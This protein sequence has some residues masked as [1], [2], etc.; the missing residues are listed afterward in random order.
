[1][2]ESP[3][4]V[5]FVRGFGLSITALNSRG[6]PQPACTVVPLPAVD[7]A[8]TCRNTCSALPGFQHAL[9]PCDNTT[10][11]LEFNCPNACRENGSKKVFT[12]K[13]PRR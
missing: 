9:L 13:L 8:V 1:M 12:R 7:E 5:S 10:D 11:K 4:Q 6:R 2:N 3:R